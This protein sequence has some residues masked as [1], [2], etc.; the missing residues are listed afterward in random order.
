MNIL[1]DNPP[2]TV[3][4]DSL[5]YEI[6]SNFRESILFELMIQDDDLTYE[7]KLYQA[8]ELYYPRV[9][10]NVEE[11]I[12]KI[13]WFYNGGKIE[14][15]KH[16]SSKVSS[17]NIKSPNIYSF[18]YDDE[19]IFSAFLSQYNIDLSDIEYLHWWK[20]K[21]LFASLSKENKINEIMSYRAIELSD[22]KDKEQ[23]S[24]YKKM[25]DMYSI[26]KGK[27]EQEKIN[28]IEEALINGNID[29]LED[30]LKVGD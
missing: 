17:K 8:L 16:N 20:F 30:L 6:N 22:I 28:N 24:Y 18:D 5:E 14:R 13:V 15:V 19:Y 9:P 4:I 21:A 25:K 7:E 23:R 3:E 2:K 29:K 1:I 26:P 11:A 10:N 12:N 27:N